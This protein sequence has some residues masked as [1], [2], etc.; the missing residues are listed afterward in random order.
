MLCGTYLTVAVYYIMLQSMTVCTMVV[1]R[2]SDGA[3]RSPWPSDTVEMPYS[4]TLHL[5]GNHDNTSTVSP[6]HNPKD[7]SEIL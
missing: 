3:E 6:Q 5:H 1:L 4:T 7:S 2:D